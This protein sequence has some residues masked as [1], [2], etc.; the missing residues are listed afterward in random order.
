MTYDLRLGRWQ[1]VLADV[2]CDIVCCDPPFSARVHA[3][4]R[5]GSSTRKSTLVYDGIT[6][7]ET[8][9]FAESWAPRTKWWAV[10][11][12]D[13]LGARWWEAAWQAQGWYVFAPVVMLRECP[14]PRMSADG[15]TSAADYITIARRRTRLPKDRM[16]SRPGYY[17]AKHTNGAGYAAERWHPGGKSVDL[18]RALIRDYSRPGDLICDP[19]AGG[20]TTLLA[21]IQTGRLAIGAEC[22]PTTHAK[23]AARLANAKVTV[24]W[25]DAPKAVQ[26]GLL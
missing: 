26:E 18:M 23:A 24:D 3:G 11:F 9:A 25:L 5:T 21:A 4:Q 17:V 20:G 6:E 8:V 19:C 1:D 22:D 12:S 13:H 15:P 2:E 10:I 16:G 14:T 7:A